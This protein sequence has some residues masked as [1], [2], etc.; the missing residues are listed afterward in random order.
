VTR[1]WWRQLA[2]IGPILAIVLIA[3]GALAVRSIA[4]EY[5]PVHG[6]EANQA[7]K[8]G[9]LLETGRYV[10]DPQDH[11]GPTLYYAALVSLFLTGTNSLADADIR[12]MRLVPVVFSV[13]TLLLLALVRRE[14]GTG[15]VICA[16]L[17]LCASPAFT[18]YSRYFIQETLL[19]F[20]MFAAIVCGIRYFRDPGAGWAIGLGLSLSLMHATKETAVL[21]YAAALGALGMLWIADRVRPFAE[22]PIDGFRG[23]HVVVAVVVGL[24]TS[25]V[26][27]TAFFTHWRGPV[28]S[29][30]TYTNYFRRAGG[31]GIHDKPW[32]YYVSSLWY[33]KRAPGPWWSEGHVLLL[34]AAGA[35]V[36]F[37]SRRRNDEAPRDVLLPRFI[38]LFTLLLAI[39]YSII[40]YKTPWTVLSIYFGVVLLAGLAVARAV[41]IA[42]GI[43]RRGLV[44]A[45]FGIVLAH[46][47]VQ[48]WRAETVYAADVRNPYVYAHTSTALVRFIDQV[49]AI[50]DLDPAGRNLSIKIVQPDA[51]YWPLPWYLRRYSNVRY[52]HAVPDDPN[53]A[54]LIVDPKLTEQVA[55]QFSRPYY[56]PFTAGLRPG[57]LR[58]VYVRQD[59]WD[60]YLQSRPPA[61]D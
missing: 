5:R 9:K 13:G 17:L 30:L 3:C 58:A 1:R 11:H 53:A 39:L 37:M 14:M 56:G 26:L 51:D 50:A 59:L 25:L 10:Y 32:Y 19:V 20:F 4:L 45:A 15:A 38:A 31:A 16:A 35:V 48:S 22:V 61:A 43:W 7:Y 21:A 40:P 41:A 36:A 24:V 18:Y 28:D 57:V 27:Y 42:P 33:T 60:R 6:D 44:L 23:S 47:G 49:E 55:A 52:I 54:I 2:G 34:G 46:L 8:A 29:V 12:T